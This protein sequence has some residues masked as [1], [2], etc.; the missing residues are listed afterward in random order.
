[1][2]R[3]SSADVG[4]ARVEAGWRPGPGTDVSVSYE[5][6][7]DRI[8]E[9]GSL[10]GAELAAD[11][12][13]NVSTVYTV[14]ALDMVVGRLRQE[15][16]GGLSLSGDAHW[17]GR[18]ED[19]PT[20][21]GRTSD[22]HSLADMAGR[23]GTLQLSREGD[24]G[25]RELALSAGLEGGRSE[26]DSD[27]AGTYSGSAFTSGSL[28]KDDALGLFAQ[29]RVDLLPETLSATAGWR[30]DSDRIDYK[31]KVTPSNDGAASFRHVSPRV[32]LDWN[33]D[34]DWTFYALY[35]EAFRAPTADE[36]TAL[37]PFAA[38]P[39]NPVQTR[40]KELGARARPLDGVTI[41]AALFR[42]DVIDEI[43]YDPTAGSFGENV[44]VPRTRRVGV[45]WSAGWK[46]GPWEARAGYAFTRA[47][48]QSD[49][50]MSKQPSGN[51]QVVPGDVMPMSPEHKGTLMAAYVPAPG[52]RLS[53]D[54]VCVGAQR[55]VG[56]EANLQPRLPA[57]CSADLGVSVERG[58]W[59]LGLRGTNV[60][61]ARY[62]QRGIISKLSG[63]AERFYVPAS[64]AGV[65][66]SL[67]WRWAAT[68]SLTARRSLGDVL[69]QLRGGR[70][71]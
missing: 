56:D 32:G 68:G 55:L 47:T 40:S 25:G 17:R 48:F 43:Y 11:P 49:V 19:T 63:R 67:S 36:L 54:G 7:D 60:T 14:G 34:P 18:R 50:T 24:W 8:H 5:R 13:Q 23:G 4:T 28:V 45:D 27:S 26:S 62:A 30:Y 15:L 9:A 64:A 21:V 6:A 46:R 41:T 71:P 22:S 51:Q 37:G 31:D 53:A 66:A 1:W 16:P 29:A 35:A 59:S 10:T 44:N 69:A 3:S 12:T 65:E 2:R 20:N 52:W 42:T 33:P 61:D 39:L 70:T 57:Y 38:Q 58:D